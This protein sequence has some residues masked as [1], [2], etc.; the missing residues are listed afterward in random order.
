MITADYQLLALITT[1]YVRLNLQVRVYGA[2]EAYG[3]HDLLER[4]YDYVR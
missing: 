2:G 3:L 4:G 1:D